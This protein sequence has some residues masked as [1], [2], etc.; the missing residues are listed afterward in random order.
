[1]IVDQK[2]QNRD[3]M[4]MREDNNKFYMEVKDKKRVKK[5]KGPNSHSTIPPY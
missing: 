3:L 2:E 1:M 5:Q 4:T